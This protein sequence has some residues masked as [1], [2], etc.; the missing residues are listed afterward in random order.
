MPSLSGIATLW[1]GIHSYTLQ[2]KQVT[3]QERFPTKRSKKDRRHIGIDAH[4][5]AEFATLTFILGDGNFN[6]NIKEMKLPKGEEYTIFST[7]IKRERYFI[8][9]DFNMIRHEAP[10]IA[11][12][13][14]YFLNKNRIPCETMDQN[15]LF[16]MII[17]RQYL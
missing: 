11:K 7:N 2:K 10:H 17:P 4:V 13:G 12:L 8:E 16:C 9:V 5:R 14:Y 1:T 3:F 6:I 15:H